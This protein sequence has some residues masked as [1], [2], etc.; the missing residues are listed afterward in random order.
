MEI[1]LRKLYALKE[2]E[3]NNEIIIPE[4]YYKK[5]DIIRIENLLIKG[6]IYVNLED[7]VTLSSE[8]TGTFILPCAIT[9]EEVPYAFSVDIEE[10]I[11]ENNE[12]NEFSLELLDVLW[13]NIVSE[14]PIRVVKPGV[15]TKSQKGVG[16]E[17]DIED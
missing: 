12:N 5:T 6:R 9:L 16:W 3:I 14:V 15:S 17:L 13:E 7:S 4:E 1:D 10:D 8:I 2:L 11:E